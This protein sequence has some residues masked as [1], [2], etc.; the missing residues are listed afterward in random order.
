MTQSDIYSCMQ[1][2]CKL[3]IKDKKLVRQFMK[4]KIVQIVLKTVLNSIMMAVMSKKQGN[5]SMSAHQE[6]LAYCQFV[7]DFLNYSFV[8]EQQM[9]F[10]PEEGE[11]AAEAVKY[12]HLIM[13]MSIP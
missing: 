5:L 10:K 12:D 11:G 8:K 2:E 1:S 9:D 3:P 13:L 7:E 4:S 6:E